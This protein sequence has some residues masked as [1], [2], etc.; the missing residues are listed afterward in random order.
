MKKIIST[1]LSLCMLASLALCGLTGCGVPEREFQ[2]V[3]LVIG[4]GMGENHILNA[5]DYYGL[6]TPSFLADKATYLVTNSL[7]GLTDSAAGGTALATGKKV[8]NSN[9]AQLEGKDIKQITSIAK[10]SKMKTGVI[11]TDVLSGATPAA[12][13]AHSPSREETTTIINSQVKSNVDLLVG[14]YSSTYVNRSDLFTD[15]GYTFVDSAKEMEEAKDAKKLV[16]VLRY[17]DSEYISM[18][19][20]HFQLKQTAKFAVEYLEN[21][22][23]FFLMIEGAY[24]DKHSHNNDFEFAMAE[25]RSLIDTIEYLYE[26]ASDGKTAVFITADHETGGLMRAQSEDDFS[27]MLYTSTNH[28]TTPVPLFVKNYTFKPEKLGYSADDI[29]Q[30]TWVFEACK[31][32]IKGK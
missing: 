31:A 26:Y 19:E 11:T 7:D 18:C 5:I 13:S 6:E 24:I 25:T 9:V 3:I 23:G 30:N 14:R 22:N 2:N 29:P 15:K 16:S 12:F 32:I 1:I 4:D 10:S 20:D 17:I 27:G 28:T 21:K 8:H